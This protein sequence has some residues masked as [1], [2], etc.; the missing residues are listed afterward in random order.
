MRYEILSK[1]IDN[2][3]FSDADKAVQ[4][5]KEALNIATEL[6]DDSKIAYSHRD[7]GYGEYRRNNKTAALKEFE[8]AEEI[9][10]ILNDSLSI[11]NIKDLKAVVYI[12]MKR[13][14]TALQLLNQVLIFNY[15]NGLKSNYYFTLLNISN[16][17]LAK[18]EYDKALDGYL[19]LLDLSKGSKPPNKELIA[20][21]YCNIGEIF[22]SEGQFD[23]SYKYRKESLDLY[24]EID[25][26]DGIASLESDIGLSLIKLKDYTLAGGYLKKAREDYES[27]KF[28]EGIRK[29]V[30]N[31]VILYM[32]TN[33]FDE[34]L[35][36]CKE[37]EMLSTAD[38]D[39]IML[40]RCANMCAEIYYKT[41]QYKLATDYFKKYIDLNELIDL[42]EN[43]QNIAELETAYLT[44][45][46]GYENKVLKKENEIQKEKLRS[47]GILLLVISVGVVIALVLL[48]LLRNKEKK[49]RIQNQNL[50]EHIRSMD[51]LFSIISHDLRSPFVGFAG[52]TEM[53]AND[54]DNFS[55][56][57]ISELSKTMNKSV[58]N[59]M[60][61]ITN[62]FDWARIKQGEL[63]FVPKKIGL[64]KSVSENFELI[65]KILEQKRIQFIK[66]I[67]HELYVNADEEMFNSILRNLLT[68]AVK[69]TSNK[70]EVT[71]KAT[72][73]VNNFVEIA[74]TDN[75][76]GMSDSLVKKLFRIDEHVGRE[77]TAGEESTGLGLLLCKEFVEKHGGKIWAEG[78]EGVGSTFYFTIPK[79]S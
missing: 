39:T 9:Y 79:A 78:K 72:E 49:I 68:N 8:T 19:K 70:G 56:D 74:I 6:K 34:A 15:N 66:I 1:L 45:G 26:K 55:R 47:R 22:Y 23:L 60:R 40:A 69:F 42:R 25:L 30:E 59:L 67:P 3:I 63:N 50:E 36:T 11:T 48:I 14:D 21:L 51:K 53:M 64:L 54:I 46:R 16:I 33:R 27:I 17:F 32:E 37:L 62:L 4:Y 24:K 57:E 73:T 58:N 18:K 13:Y 76:I 2:Y 35:K 41:G 77:G 31:F 20:T 28:S 65:Q 71:V 44:E 38:K 10:I 75:G 5:S 52:M 12:S 61:M 29:A 43:K 7:L